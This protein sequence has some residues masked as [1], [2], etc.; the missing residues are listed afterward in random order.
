MFDN[1]NMT[2]AMAPTQFPETYPIKVAS[3]D[4]LP[5][6]H[7]QWLLHRK[8]AMA[9]RTMS[10]SDSI[11]VFANS[12][13]VSAMCAGTSTVTRTMPRADRRPC[14]LRVDVFIPGKIHPPESGVNSSGKIFSCRYDSRAKTAIRTG[15]GKRS[16]SIQGLH[17]GWAHLVSLAPHGQHGL[18]CATTQEL[19]LASHASVHLTVAF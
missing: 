16:E 10:E 13:A 9:S 19:I 17:R 18:A 14:R 8:S 7:H 1:G 2:Y 5:V 3:F 15:A 6:N 12:R 11:L 4:L